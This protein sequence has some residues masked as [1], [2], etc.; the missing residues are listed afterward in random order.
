MVIIAINVSRTADNS[1]I[2]ALPQHESACLAYSSPFPEKKLNSQLAA[3]Q[4]NIM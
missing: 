1:F 4:Y 3:L 2:F